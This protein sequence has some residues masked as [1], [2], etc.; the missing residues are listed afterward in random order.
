MTGVLIERGNSD[1]GTDTTQGQGPVKTYKAR[2]T[3]ACQQTT[4][5]WEEAKKEAL[6][7]SEGA[8]PPGALISGFW[9]L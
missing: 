7:V 3:K 4:E 6:Q 9:P 2:N 8:W 5:S 1:T